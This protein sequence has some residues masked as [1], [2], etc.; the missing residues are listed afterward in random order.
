[1]PEYQFL[2]QGTPAPGGSKSA[3]VV[4]NKKT[5]QP[6]RAKATGRIIVNITDNAGEGNKLWR[7]V[8]ANTARCHFTGPPLQCALKCQFIF[9]MK[10]PQSH[11]NSKGE[12]KPSAP[13]NHTGKPD[14]LKLARSTEDALTSIVWADDSQ[15]VKLCTEKRYCGPGEVPGCS[16]RIVT[17]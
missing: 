3:F 7:S 9:Y 13:T 12:L 1:M 11:L 8:V 5:G 16:I 14:A 15:T 4:T 6:I 10:R 17:L 2:V